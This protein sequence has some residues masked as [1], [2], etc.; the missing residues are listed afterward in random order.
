MIFQIFCKNC[1]SQLASFPYM[2]HK[3]GRVCPS[4]TEAIREGNT[5]IFGINLGFW[6]TAHLPLS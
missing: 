2:D 4:C 1:C 3:V 6:E 5:K